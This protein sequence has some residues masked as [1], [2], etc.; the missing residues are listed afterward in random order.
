MWPL[1]ASILPLSNRLRGCKLTSQHPRRKKQSVCAS[2]EL[3]NNPT[4][5]CKVLIFAHHDR[6]WRRRRRLSGTR[7]AVWVID[8]V[9]QGFWLKINRKIIFEA[10]G[11]SFLFCTELLFFLVAYKDG[12]CCEEALCCCDIRLGGGLMGIPGKYL[13]LSHLFLSD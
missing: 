11:P 8:N 12:G 7:W 3:Q 9:L 2:S 4:A 5:R 10:S 6:Q 1:G 13:H